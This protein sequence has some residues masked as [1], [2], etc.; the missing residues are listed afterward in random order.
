MC[1]RGKL[2]ELIVLIK[3]ELYRKYVTY[4]S[5][6]VPMLYVL[7]NKAIHG[8]L[9]S[10]L[11]FYKKLAKDSKAYG[12]KL[13]PY[14]PCVANMTVDGEQYT[15]VWHVNDLKCSHKDPKVNTRLA[16]YCASIYGDT[17]TVH[18]GKLNYYLGINIDYGAQK[19]K[20]EIFM[21]EYPRNILE[22]FRE[23]RGIGSP[24]Q[25][26]LPLNS[27]FEFEMKPTRIMLHC[28]KRNQW[29]SNTSLTSSYLCLIER[30]V[31]SRCL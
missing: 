19:G 21:M 8:L 3:P 16:A 7:M 11:R 4:T 6:G 20:V 5:N 22:D 30:G 25:Q 31:M 12:F 18:R 13:N 29:P 9:K 24:P 2:A 23:D 28:L 17:V 27:C 15:V 14:D 1:L 26:L 10:A